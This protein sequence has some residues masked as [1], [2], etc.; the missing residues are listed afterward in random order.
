MYHGMKKVPLGMPL[1]PANV[2]LA[3]APCRLPTPVRTRAG[4]ISA[5][6]RVRSRPPPCAPAAR[7]D[8]LS[9]MLRGPR[10]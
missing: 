8:L 5:D 9:E 3:R 10:L 4:I 7:P 6:P 1:S 2:R